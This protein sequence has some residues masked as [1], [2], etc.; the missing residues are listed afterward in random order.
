MNKDT[1]LKCQVC[2]EPATGSLTYWCCSASKYHY[3]QWRTD[4]LRKAKQEWE[5]TRTPYQRE[6]LSVF[7]SDN[8]RAQFL[9]QHA[10]TYPL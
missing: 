10:P 3:R 9:A 5:R 7:K 8:T 1:R 4:R 2:G 6:V